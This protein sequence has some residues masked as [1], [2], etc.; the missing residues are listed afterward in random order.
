MENVSYFYCISVICRKFC[1]IN[2][3]FCQRMQSSQF[4]SLGY[5]VHYYYYYGYCYHYYAN[6]MD[7]RYT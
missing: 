1:F 2:F 7:T 6:R 5:I 3:V 4:F